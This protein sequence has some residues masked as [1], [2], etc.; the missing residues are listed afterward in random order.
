MEQRLTL[1]T[2]GVADLNRS[3]AFYE[4]LGWARSMRE[5]E[6]VAFF[7]LGG[8]GLSLFPLADLAAD[9]GLPEERLT[10]FRGIALAHNVRRRE[11]VDSAAA[12]FIRL[13]GSMVKPAEDKIWG[14][15]GAYAADPDGHLWEIAWN[16]DF[17][18]DETGNV[19]MPQ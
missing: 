8:I 16:P 3:V 2:L 14:G 4:G 12:S 13:G 6:G 19:K 15:Y 5:A 18:L 1:V 7:Q 17:V 10:R 9:A 11:E